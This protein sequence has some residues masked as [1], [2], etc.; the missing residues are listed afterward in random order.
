MVRRPFVGGGDV[1]Q[2][3][4]VRPGLAVGQRAFHGVAGVF[5]VHEMHAFDDAAILHSRHA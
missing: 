4:L 5:D 1:Q 3:E 2:G